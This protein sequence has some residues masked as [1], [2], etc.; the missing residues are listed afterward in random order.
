MTVTQGHLTCRSIPWTRRL[1]FLIRPVTTNSATTQPL[2]VHG[3]NRLLRI[4]LV[5]KGNKP[6]PARFARVHIP[7]NTCVTHRTKGA[8]GFSKGFVIDFG[9]QVA[10]KNV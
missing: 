10:N 2:A 3:R 1:T 7:H 9:T 8:K 4:S 6:I 5:T